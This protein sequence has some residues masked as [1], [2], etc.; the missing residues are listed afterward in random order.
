MILP[1]LSGSYLLLLMG[2]YV[3]ILDALDQF[4]DALSARDISAAMDPAMSTLLPVGLGVV[5]GVVLVGNLLEWLLR[6]YR[7]ATLGV[8]LGLLLGSTVGLWPFQV[9]VS[10]Q[11]R[12]IIKGRT[13]TLEM[14]SEIDEEDWLTE[15]F[16]PN[17]TQIVSS[18]ALIAIGFGSTMGVAFIGGKE[19]E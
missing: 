8:L 4:K 14:I 6:K 3:P 9:G 1:G 19:D 15:T 13:V 2:Q 11:V 5:A 7:K 18:L 10:P 12:D 16:R 17:T